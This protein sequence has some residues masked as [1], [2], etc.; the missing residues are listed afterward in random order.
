MALTW[1]QQFGYGAGILLAAADHVI[2][3]FLRKKQCRGP[4]IDVSLPF[5]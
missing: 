3:E 4:F 5:V 2:K 1:K